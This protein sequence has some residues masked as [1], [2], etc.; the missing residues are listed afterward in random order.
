GNNISNLTV[1]NVNILRSGENGIELDG[2]GSNIIF[3]NDTINQVNNNGILVYTYTGFIFRGNVVKNI[4]IIPGRGKS[5][6]GQYD[7][8]QYVPFIANPS[9][10]SLIEN[11]LLDSLGYVGIDF[12][13]GN[14][15]VQKNI[16]SNYNLIKDDGGCIYTWNAGGSTKTY[17]NQ[18]V[19]SNIVYNSIGSVEG[20]YNGYPGASGIYM[21][22]CAVNVEIKDNTVFNCTGW[23]LV[24]HGNN[25]MNVIGNTFYNNGTPKEGGQ[26]LIG[27]SSCGANFN[28]T[29]NNNIFFSKN[30]YQLI[31]RE[32]NE[33]ADLSKYGTFDNNYYCR[34]FDD[35]LT[36]SFNRNYQKSSLMALTNWQFISGKDITSKPSPINYM[37]YTL[38]NL[39]GGDIISNG[40]FTSGSSNWFAY[41]DNN[42]HN[43]TWDNSGKINGGS[44]KTS[45]NSFASVV[46]SLVNIATDFSPA[47]TKSK[48][49]ILRFDAVSS[50][51]K[52]TII[53]ELTPNAAP[54]LPLTTSKGVTVGTIK[55]KYEVYFTILRDDLNSTSRLLFQMLEGN[56][57][58]WIDNVSLQEANI[59]ISNPNDSILFFYNDTKT[60]KTFSLPSGKNYIDVK[61]TVYSSSVQLSQFTSIILMYK[62]QITTGIKVNNDALSINIYPN[63]TNKLA[64]VNYQLTNNSEVKIV[65]Y[66]LTGREVMQLLNEKQIA[67]EHRVNLDTSELQN[68]IYFM[69]MNINGEQITKKFIVNK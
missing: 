40:T 25:N 1:Q 45:F 7:A 62:G 34:P 60:N 37:P 14:T 12:R 48:V 52:T 66:E 21:D 53:C 10:I 49:F 43:F 28:N 5:G 46:P 69:N 22:D 64:V 23:G 42:N 17:T 19:I 51:D 4:G 8:L 50:V 56:Q 2:S 44:I 13:A 33:T 65:V 3:E 57:S 30:D 15:T 68:G 58:V 29:L 54:W 59:N 16:V 32:E 38:I 35:V 27:L 63:P 6:D 61:Q 31:A 47:V 41:S 9:E 36:F 67:G 11:N 55:K 20:V 26:Y 24:L 39:T 18:R